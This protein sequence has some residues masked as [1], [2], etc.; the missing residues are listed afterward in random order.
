MRKIVFLALTLLTVLSA[1]LTL[2]KAEAAC[3]WTCGPCGPVCPCSVC[4]P[5]YP[6]CHACP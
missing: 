3:N 2:P 1:V 4:G 5:P 6:P